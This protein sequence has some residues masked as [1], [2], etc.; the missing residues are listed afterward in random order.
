MYCSWVDTWKLSKLS[1]WP[2]ALG[3]TH[4]TKWGVQACSLLITSDSEF[5]KRE[6]EKGYSQRHSPVTLQPEYQ[7]WI[8]DS[9]TCPDRQY[10]LV[11]G[12]G[13]H[14][15]LYSKYYRMKGMAPL[16]PF[17]FDVV[18]WFASPSDWSEIM[19]CLRQSGLI[20]GRCFS[21]LREKTKSSLL[22]RW[23]SECEGTFFPALN[24]KMP[25]SRS[26]PLF[27]PGI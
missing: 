19:L 13:E 1:G 16:W 6:K 17:S 12:L 27:R 9:I 4:S 14:S 15:D 5:W 20:F 2:L 23:L 7:T 8:A 21:T 26:Q 10:L 22:G 3:R 11:F 25:H 18:T 24:S